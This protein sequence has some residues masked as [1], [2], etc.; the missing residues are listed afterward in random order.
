MSSIFSITFKPSPELN[1][2]VSP[3]WEYE[4][5]ENTTNKGDDT[6]GMVNGNAQHQGTTNTIYEAN[7]ITGEVLFTPSVLNGTY[8]LYFKAQTSSITFTVGR[9]SQSGAQ[10]PRGQTQIIL[11][12][13]AQ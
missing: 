2:A 8:K 11:Q 7:R 13:I 1:P 9:T 4:D 5:I 10:N 6:Y 12:E 3:H